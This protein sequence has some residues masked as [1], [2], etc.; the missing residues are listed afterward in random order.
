MGGRSEESGQL[1]GKLAPLV[2]EVGWSHNL[3]IPERCKDALEREFYLLY[4]D[5][6]RVQPVVAQIG[7]SHN[8]TMF[9]RCKDPLCAN[10]ASA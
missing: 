5:D 10:F 2:R 7:W 6:Q 8:L 1:A 3:A 9:Q 4:G